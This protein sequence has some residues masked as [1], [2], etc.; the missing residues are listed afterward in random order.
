VLGALAGRSP[1]G[2]NL[3]QAIRSISWLSNANVVIESPLR[4]SWPRP[5]CQV[6]LL[7]PKSRPSL[8]DVLSGQATA[9]TLMDAVALQVPV[10]VIHGAQRKP[11]MRW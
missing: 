7:S 4:A 9:R 5:I 6:F 1:G 11:A 2:V 3:A 10:A 8:D